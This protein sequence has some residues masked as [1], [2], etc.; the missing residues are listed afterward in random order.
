MTRPASQ[1]PARTSSRIRS[2]GIGLHPNGPPSAIF[3]TRNA[4][5]FSP[6]TLPAYTCPVAREPL[7]NAIQHYLREI[8]KLGSGGGRVSV[9]ALARAQG[10]STASASAMVKKLAAL[11]LLEHAPYRGIELTSSGERV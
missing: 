9:T 2:N 5:V 4:V 7:T 3:S 1:P 11:D 8:Y 6:R 10:V